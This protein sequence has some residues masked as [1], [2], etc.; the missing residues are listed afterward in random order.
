MEAKAKAK[1]IID[2]FTKYFDNKNK[3]SP[4][5]TDRHCLNAKNNSENAKQCALIHVNGIIEVIQ[6]NSNCCEYSVYMKI[7]T[8]TY[9]QD[10][11]EEIENL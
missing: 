10:I 11:K 8:V 2:L 7:E 9:W 6:N 1:E 5:D 3:F 4:Y